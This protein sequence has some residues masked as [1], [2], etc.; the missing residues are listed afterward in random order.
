MKKTGRI[1]YDLDKVY[2]MAEYL[3][4]IHI[5]M[6]RAYQAVGA[7]SEKGASPAGAAWTQTRERPRRTA[8]RAAGSRETWGFIENILS[9]VS[10]RVRRE[11]GKKV[12]C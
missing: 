9:F 4:L 1:R 6:H 12:P 2:F 5:W 3:S 10:Y 11:T 7:T 8:S